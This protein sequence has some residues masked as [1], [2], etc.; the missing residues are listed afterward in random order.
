MPPTDEPKVLLA[1]P[2]LAEDRTLR[3]RLSRDYVLRT[4]PTIEEAAAAMESG[5]ID[6]VVSEQQYADGRGVDFAAADLRV[7]QGLLQ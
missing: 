2:E 7:R 3:K 4:A 6:L 5:D 1:G